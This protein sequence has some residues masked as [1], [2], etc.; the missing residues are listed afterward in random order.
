MSSVKGFWMHSTNIPLVA[1]SI[2]KIHSM[3]ENVKLQECIARIIPD[4]SG[5]TSKNSHNH[6]QDKLVALL[7]QQVNGV[8][9]E[10]SR[11]TSIED[12]DSTS[13]RC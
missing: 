8:T 5:G 2:Q 7:I 11:E 4:S 1:K 6:V 13:M 10:S 12:E 3:T 9:V